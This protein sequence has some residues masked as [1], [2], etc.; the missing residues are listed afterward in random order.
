MIKLIFYGIL[1]YML[2]KL[3]FDFVIP[4]SKATS[5]I[6][7]KIREQQRQFNQQQATP[8]QQNSSQKPPASDTEYIEFEEV[9]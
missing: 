9:K 8:Q 6:K 1:I 5:Q 4:V 7:S 2:Y 3:I